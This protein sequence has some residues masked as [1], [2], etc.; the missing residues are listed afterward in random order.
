MP[1]TGKTFLNNMFGLDFERLEKKGNFCFLDMVMA[2]ASPTV[3]EI[4]LNEV[5]RLG[6][7]V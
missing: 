3:V 2:K 7:D 6:L 4:I 1:R 5:I